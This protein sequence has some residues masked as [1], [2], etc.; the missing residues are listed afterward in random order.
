MNSFPSLKALVA[1]LTLLISSQL[2]AEEQKESS[3]EEV[4]EPTAEELKEIYIKALQ[5]Y[6]E[7][8]EVKR[9]YEVYVS[10]GFSNFQEDTGTTVGDGASFRFASGVQYNK[11]FGLEV[12]AEQA[13]PLAPS[14]LLED[15]RQNIDQ[16]ILGY[17]ITTQGNKYVGLLGKFSFDVAKDVVLVGKIGVA[18]YEAHKFTADL[19]LDNKADDILFNRTRLIGGASGYSPIVSFGYEIPIPY[20]DSKKT[21]GEL[22]L[23]QLFDE[24]VKNLSLNVTLKYT[25]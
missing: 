9:D 14:S 4:N 23:T 10:G 11:W 21:S 16:K 20:R 2:F 18:K 22:S 6:Y 8:K 15:L 3:D 12:Y 19:T 25:F 1:I 17:S 13:P 5:A 7:K 24:E